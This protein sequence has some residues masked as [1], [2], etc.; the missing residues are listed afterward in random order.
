MISLIVD[1]FDSLFSF[2]SRKF[3]RRCPTSSKTPPI[4]SAFI[5]FSR[6]KVTSGLPLM[7]STVVQTVPSS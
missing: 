4:R 2:L 5:D 7:M 1:Y 3:D 6:Q